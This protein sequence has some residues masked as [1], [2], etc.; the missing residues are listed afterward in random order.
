MTHH[1]HTRVVPQSHPCRTSVTSR[2]HPSRTPKFTLQVKNNMYFCGRKLGPIVQWI[3]RKFP[4]LQI[5]VRFLVGL[6]NYFVNPCNSSDCRGFLLLG[7]GV[8]DGFFGER[9]FK[10]YIVLLGKIMFLYFDL[11]LD[12]VYHSEFWLLPPV[13]Y[14]FLILELTNGM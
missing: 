6:R 2:S 7:D 13:L 11:S 5:Q 14:Y 3:E 8:G 4:K 10:N 12:S 1:S 9:Y